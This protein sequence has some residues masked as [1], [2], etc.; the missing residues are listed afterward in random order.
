MKLDYTLD[1][2][3][4]LNK[5]AKRLATLE[6]KLQDL[7]SKIEDLYTTIKEFTFKTNL[8]LSDLLKR[9]KTLEIDPDHPKPSK[10][11]TENLA[12]SIY[13]IQSEIKPLLEDQ[14]K[15]LIDRLNKDLVYNGS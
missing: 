8:D 15:P 10:I 11:R 13:Q 5:I 2:L 4:D 12:K 9:V 1:S 3:R 6:N 7:P 14:I